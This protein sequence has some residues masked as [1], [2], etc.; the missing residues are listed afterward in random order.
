MPE[1]GVGLAVQR[2]VV[3]PH[4]QVGP[5][6]TDEEHHAPERCV[7]TGRRQNKA[8]ADGDFHDA[9]DENPKRWVSEDRWDDGLKPCGVGEVL[10]TDVDVCQTKD[11]TQNS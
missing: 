11:N 10:N 5:V 9:R 8:D 2:D 7:T 3:D 6:N 4:V 1:I